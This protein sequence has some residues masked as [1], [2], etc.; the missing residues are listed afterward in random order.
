VILYQLSPSQPLPFSH[1][2]GDIIFLRSFGRPNYESTRRNIPMEQRH[3]YRREKLK[4]PHFS[5]QKC[6]SFIH[7]EH[8]RIFFLFSP[9]FCL[10]Q[11][12]NVWNRTWTRSVSELCNRSS[13]THDKRH[14]WEACHFLFAF[15]WC[16]ATSMLR[17]LT[18]IQRPLVVQRGGGKKLVEKIHGTLTTIC[19]APP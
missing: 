17:Y 12:D 1:E 13:D 10:W 3:F 11:T 5:L 4:S 18:Q 14:Y 19:E 15:D 2:D 9:C 7:Q 6:S 16:V 8:F